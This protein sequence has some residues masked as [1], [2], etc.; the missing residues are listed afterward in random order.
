MIPL[1]F[2]AF[3]DGGHGG[4]EKMIDFYRE[5]HSLGET[6]RYMLF[7]ADYGLSSLIY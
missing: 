5:G 4:W 7:L 3:V 1:L 2:T 6:T